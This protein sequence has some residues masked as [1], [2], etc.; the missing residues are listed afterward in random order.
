MAP[1]DW[2]SRP[3]N[4]G[5]AWIAAAA[6]AGLLTAP[7]AAWAGAVAGQAGIDQR[8]VS[9]GKPF[10]L[11]ISLTGDLTDLQGEPAFEVPEGL[12]VSSKRQVSDL[13]VGP[14]GISRSVT[15]VYVVVPTK[16]GTFQLGPFAV[17]RRDQQ[18]LIEAVEVVVQKP[19]LPPFLAP[20]PRYTL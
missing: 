20:G 9:L 16:P 19:R 4:R 1:R 10:I 2:C 18:V 7:S 13:S 11:T 5:L 12:H 14:T 3:R 8:A 17:Q 6:L 15:F